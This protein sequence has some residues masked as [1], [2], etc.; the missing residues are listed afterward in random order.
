MSLFRCGGGGLS[1]D[2]IFDGVLPDAYTNVNVTIPA[3]TKALALIVT[4]PDD[5]DEIL[6]GDVLIYNIYRSSNSYS[7]NYCKPGDTSKFIGI[8]INVSQ[9]LLRLGGGNGISMSNVPVKLFA[10]DLSPE[11][12]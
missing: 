4:N 8:N 9:S 6:Q 12:F 3:G 1:K 10:V 2:L 7:Q 11:D 5:T